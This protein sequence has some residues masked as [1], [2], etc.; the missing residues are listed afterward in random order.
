MKKHTIIQ[1]SQ[2]LDFVCL[3]GLIF[4]VPVNSYGHVGTASS[5]NHTFFPGQA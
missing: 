5:A 2:M 1:T 4:N 3:F